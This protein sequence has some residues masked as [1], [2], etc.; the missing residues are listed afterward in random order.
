MA[1]M[2][3]CNCPPMADVMR[4][5]AGETKP[6][7]PVHPTPANL[8][9]ILRPAFPIRFADLLTFKPGTEH[10]NHTSPKG[11]ARRS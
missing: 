11:R 7:C 6:E 10:Y 1:R 9:E 5:R 3:T 2:A 8:G 4:G